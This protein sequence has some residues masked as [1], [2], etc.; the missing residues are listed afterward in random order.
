MAIFGGTAGMVTMDDSRAR[1]PTSPGLQITSSGY[2]IEG[3]PIGLVAGLNS[4]RIG[5]GTDAGAAFTTTI[6]SALTGSGSLDKTDLGTL[7]LTS[8]STYTGG[9]SV[10][11]GTLQIGDGGTS[12]SIQGNINN[13]GTLIFNRTGTLALDGA[14]TGL[15]H[16]RRIGTGT[17]TLS[18]SGSFMPSFDIQSGTVEADEQRQPRSE[19]V[20]L[21]PRCDPAQRRNAYR[22]RGGRHVRSRRY[23]R[24]QPE[25]ARWQR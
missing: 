14:I 25:P 8:E 17:T 6:A 10:S 12:G 21:G 7:I 1:F 4:V 18:G 16:V 19:P 23:L 11:F 15:G 20:D 22:H 13:N 2:R 3:G 24:R 9:T 5:D